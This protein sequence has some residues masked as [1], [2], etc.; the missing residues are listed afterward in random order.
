[1]P[2]QRRHLTNAAQLDGIA[3]TRGHLPMAAADAPVSRAICL[4]CGAG[5]VGRYCSE[6]GERRIGRADLTVRAFLEAA[7]YELTDA[8]G[9]LWRSVRSLLLHP[10]RLSEEYLVG[11][12]RP[13]LSPVQ[14]FLICNVTFFVL[15]EFLP[16][17]VFTTRLSDHL[18]GNEYGPW[19]LGLEARPGITFRALLQDQE[20]FAAYAR[21]FDAVTAGPAK[22]LIFSMIPGIALVLYVLHGRRRRHFVEHLVFATHLLA[23]VLVTIVVTLIAAVV[24]ARA[25]VLLQFRVPDNE[26]ALFS[27]VFL[28]LLLAWVL[29][30]MKHFYAQSWG[31]TA[32]KVPFF[33]LGF[34][35]VVLAYRLM[36]FMLTVRLV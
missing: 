24:L 8:D 17:Y 18:L 29:P 22:S 9:R 15:L 27:L 12:R 10:G 11:R 2:K 21:T 5:Q 1:M 20:A 30:G 31:I 7:L 26:D 35:Y 4:S 25:V 32:V 19:L 36:L 3:A 16:L 28:V 33:I 14:L 13:W 34:Y 23:V 6:C